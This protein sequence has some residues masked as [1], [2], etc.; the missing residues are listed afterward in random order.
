M[1]DSSRSGG[2]RGEEGRR[3]GSALLARHMTVQFP[4]NPRNNLMSVYGTIVVRSVSEAA[5]DRDCQSISPPRF[6]VCSLSYQRKCAFRLVCVNLRVRVE[7]WQ[8]ARV[9]QSERQIAPLISW[10]GRNVRSSTS[11]T[12]R[13]TE[14]FGVE[15]HCPSIALNHFRR[16]TDDMTP[17]RGF[18][19]Q[20]Q[21]SNHE[22]DPFSTSHV[23]ILTSLRTS[24]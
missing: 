16:G 2:A 12:C 13:H 21:M 3:G 18:W 9:V 7:A 23:S 22:Q 4:S 14:Y 11:A 24:R 10:K 20:W 17:E 5:P 6:S 19:R 1:S 8:G 15:A